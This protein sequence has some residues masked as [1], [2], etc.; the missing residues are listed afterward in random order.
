MLKLWVADL[1][2]YVDPKTGHHYQADYIRQMVSAV[3]KWHTSHELANPATDAVLKM[4]AKGYANLHGRNVSRALPILRRGLSLMVETTFVPPGPALRNRA[5]ILLRLND[6][7]PLGPRPLGAVKAWSQVAWPDSDDCPAVLTT[8]K[9][10]EMTAF[11]IAR[12][13]EPALDAVSAL[14]ALYEW[15]E[16]TD[17]P[18][19]NPKGRPMGYS[20]ISLLFKTLTEVAGVD[21]A[22][23]DRLD[24]DGRRRLVEAVVRRS[25]MQ[26]RDSALFTLEWMGANRRSE[27]SKMIWADLQTLP[28]DPE[29]ISMT[30]E[31]SKTDQEGQGKVRHIYPQSDTR[32]DLRTRLDEWRMRA[33]QI[34]GRAVRPSDPVFFRLDQ[35]SHPETG[36]EHLSGNA[37]NDRVKA[38][39]AA[40]G[41]QG[42]YSSHSLRAG[43]AT[44]AFRSG[45]ETPEVMEHLGHDDPRST[46]LYRR[47][48][49][50]HSRENPTRDPLLA[51]AE[52]NDRIT[53]AVMS[54]LLDHLNND[55]SDEP[56][57]DV[58][59]R[60]VDD[61]LET[62]D[63]H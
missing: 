45:F 41:F 40:A 34:L 23:L 11:E 39:V 2:M 10:G 4:I 7:D 30:V 18:F 55:D 49:V 56:L 48:A 36:P 42:R 15:Q 14:R 60:L 32:I 61:E 50:R 22:E 38:A 25:D 51:E 28:E 46:M 44:Q 53:D 54:R 21:P 19:P 52:E 43:L 33:E 17:P 29:V 62:R 6:S 27:V 24:D 9:D 26:V 16:G 58:I 57:R 5:L 12:H 59:A 13:A 8:M 63:D 1:A 37:I 3:G 20:G 47:N 35:A 31:R